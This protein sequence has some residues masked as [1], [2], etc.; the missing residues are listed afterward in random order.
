MLNDSDSDDGNQTPEFKEA[1]EHNAVSAPIPG[2]A[3]GIK[4]RE[5]QMIDADR[6]LNNWIDMDSN[7]D[8]EGQIHQFVHG[9]AVSSTKGVILAHE[10]GLGKTLIAL[11]AVAMDMS[12]LRKS[13]SSS[14][15]W[16]CQTL[17]CILGSLK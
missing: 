4:L 6:I 12:E 11:A 5:F 9:R 7:G 17:F 2:L 1:E 13:F 15:Y 8:G 16:Y 10:M 3:P 14:H